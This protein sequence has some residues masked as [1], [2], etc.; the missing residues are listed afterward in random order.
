MSNQPKNPKKV[1]LW[2]KFTKGIG[3]TFSSISLEADN[4]GKRI[5]D[6]AKEHMLQYMFKRDIYDL[7]DNFNL[8]DPEENKDADTAEIVRERKTLDELR[9][10]VKGKVDLVKLENYLARYPHL[11][12]I[13]PQG[14][15]KA[16]EVAKYARIVAAL[17]QEIHWVQYNIIN[18][19]KKEGPGNYDTKSYIDYWLKQIDDNWSSFNGA[20]ERLE[21][22]EE[23]L[24][25]LGFD[26]KIYSALTS[27]S[28]QCERLFRDFYKHIEEATNGI[29][30]SQQ[31]L[32]H[33]DDQFGSL[34]N[35]LFIELRKIRGYSHGFEINEETKERLKFLVEI[36]N[37]VNSLFLARFNFKLFYEEVEKSIDQISRNCYDSKGL[38]TNLASLGT[39]ID[40][41][42]V[43]SLKRKLKSK[44]KE[45]SINTLEIFL[46]ENYPHYDPIIIK[47]LRNI[48]TIRNQWPIHDNT[49]KGIK[50]VEE[51]YGTYPVDD[52]SIFWD[53]ILHLYQQSLAVLKGTMS[54][55]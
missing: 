46:Q 38:V 52:F 34:D 32:S 29:S 22:K 23:T 13:I 41:I 16:S 12:N 47:N 25:S 9:A 37:Q 21:E 15:I 26:M 44:P 42:N 11:G 27:I 6:A 35:G 7:I 3:H 39:I 28:E 45:G 51:I 55:A 1:G 5:E 8:P 20:R 19:L 54:T 50:L 53:K 17:R 14:N 43:D 33:F 31:S 18:I 49:S 30:Y 2:Y 10:Y 24:S 40:K 48:M 4:E 36:R